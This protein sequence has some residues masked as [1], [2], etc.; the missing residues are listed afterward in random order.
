MTRE[1]SAASPTSVVVGGTLRTAIPGHTYERMRHFFLYVYLYRMLTA[2][3]N[4]AHGGA[5]GPAAGVSEIATHQVDEGMRSTDLSYHGFDNKDPKVV[6]KTATAY[7]RMDAAH[8]C[9]L[10]IHG[11]FASAAA[12]AGTADPVARDLYEGLKRVCGNTRLMPQR[13]N[14]GPDRVIDRLHGRLARAM[15][16]D[17]PPITTANFLTY[18]TEAARDLRDYRIKQHGFGNHGV[19][20]CVDLYLSVYADKTQIDGIWRIVTGNAWGD[21]AAY[22]F[23]VGDYVR[24]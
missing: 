10:G 6:D 16:D 17:T 22:K 15:L 12:K 13:I 23:T 20:A 24:F 7:T 8:F 18:V 2:R 11:P 9:N 3:L 4:G 19:V 5:F 21:C 1:H 14:I